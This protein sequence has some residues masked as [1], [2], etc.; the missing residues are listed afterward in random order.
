MTSDIERGEVYVDPVAV[1]F[2]RG[3][4]KQ[5]IWG[6][7]PYGEWM[8]HDGGRVIFDRR[9]RPIIRIKPDGSTEIV[10]SD[11]FIELVGQRWFHG[12][13]GCSPDRATR[14]IVTELIE[15]YDLAPELR[16]RLQRLKRGE[17]SCWDGNRRPA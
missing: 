13:F 12:G 7:C 10:P 16:R 14:K 3:I 4:R 5:A 1:S 6:L 11:E 17:I 9:Y 2:I 8:E 15:R